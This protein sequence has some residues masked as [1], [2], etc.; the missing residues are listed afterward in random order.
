MF[1]VEAHDHTQQGSV[2]IVPSFLFHAK[3]LVL[4]YLFEEKF[5]TDQGNI[6]NGRSDVVT[7][8]TD[9]DVGKSIFLQLIFKIMDTGKS[10]NGPIVGDPLIQPGKEAWFFII[11]LQKAISNAK[12]AAG[13]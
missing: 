8:L 2:H 13:L 7:D 3:A 11:V 5:Y 12:A 9:L 10:G 1:A 4:P 6:K